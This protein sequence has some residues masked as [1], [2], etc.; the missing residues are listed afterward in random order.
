MALP[1]ITD[2]RIDRLG[3][4]V[5]ND[6]PG[7]LPEGRNRLCG[8]PG[9]PLGLDR[10]NALGDQLPRLAG[11]FTSVFEA[12]RGIGAETLVLSDAGDLVA[13]NP[14]LALRL[15]ASRPLGSRLAHDEI[16]A[17]AVAMPA[18]LSRLHSPFR[19]PRHPQ[20]HTWSH[21]S[22]RIVAHNGGQ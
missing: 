1:L 19:K 7:D 13:Q 21:T 9:G 3:L 11:S 6:E 2:L 14:F 22:K 18:R 5:L 4:R 8:L 10:V 17:V 20:S 12:N 16:E 15:P